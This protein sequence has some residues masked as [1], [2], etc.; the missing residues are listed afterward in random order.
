MG[1]LSAPRAVTRGYTLV[2]LL[3]V[4][5]IAGIAVAAA[6]LAWRDTPQA[7]VEAEAR[8]LAARVELALALNQVAGRRIAL[9]AHDRGYAFWEREASGAWVPLA[10]GDE[11]RA[12]ELPEGMSVASVRA[13]S[14]PAAPGE[15]LRLTATDP[16]PLAIVLESS[17]ARA[18]V[19]SGDYAGR[20]RVARL[21]TTP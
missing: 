12:A 17:G 10:A 2:E 4:V 11:P 8:R 21:E 15:R 9:V 5:A 13:G 7:R 3:V 19:A 14:L 20:M 6:A 16:L 18:L 1:P